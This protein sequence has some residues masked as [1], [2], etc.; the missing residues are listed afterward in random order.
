MKLINQK[1]VMQYM[2]ESEDEAFRHE[3]QMKRDGWRLEHGF[4]FSNPKIRSYSKSQ[5]IGSY[6]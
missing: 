6:L 4:I 5:K 3:E 2:Y 1:T